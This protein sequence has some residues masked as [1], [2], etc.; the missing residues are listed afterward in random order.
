[1]REDTKTPGSLGY[2]SLVLALE[3]D[4]LVESR[5]AGKSPDHSKLFPKDTICY[6][7]VE[8]H[9]EAKGY[10]AFTVDDGFCEWTTRAET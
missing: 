4:T 6:Y 7:D 5:D 10:V 2:W 9:P 1:M 8:T 3:K